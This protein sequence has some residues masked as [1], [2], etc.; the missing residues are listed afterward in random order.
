MQD[1]A[2]TKQATDRMVDE[3][4]NE[5]MRELGYIGQLGDLSYLDRQLVVWT[6]SVKRA[7]RK[8]A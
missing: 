7:A 8:A 2:A 4:I 6:A 3:F 5:A 1:G